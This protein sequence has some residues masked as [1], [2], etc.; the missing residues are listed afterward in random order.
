VQYSAGKGGR[1]DNGRRGSQS[2]DLQSAPGTQVGGMKAS[3]EN[4]KKVAHD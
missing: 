4:P 3:C 1:N 2:V